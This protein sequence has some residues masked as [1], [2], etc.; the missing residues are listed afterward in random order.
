MRRQEVFLTVFGYFAYDREIDLTK[1]ER[2]L[3]MN[4]RPFPF[5]RRGSLGQAID[6]YAKDGERKALY[7]GS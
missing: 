5:A 3:T 2:A 1:G 4:V 6:A 7:T